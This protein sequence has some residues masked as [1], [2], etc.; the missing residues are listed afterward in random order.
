MAMMLTLVLLL[1]RV[2][3]IIAWKCAVLS[4]MWL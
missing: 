2:T 3:E 4:E 1:V